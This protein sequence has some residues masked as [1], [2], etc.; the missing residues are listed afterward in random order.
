MPPDLLLLPD[1]AWYLE[2]HETARDAVLVVAIVP[3]ED[4][5]REPTICFDESA[6]HH[7][8]PH[9]VMRWFVDES[10]GRSRTAAA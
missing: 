5:G 2:L 1:D 9:T 3:D 10:R 6:G 8:V 7:P 4:P